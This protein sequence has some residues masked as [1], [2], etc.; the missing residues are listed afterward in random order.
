MSIDPIIDDAETRSRFEKLFKEIRLESDRG[1]ILV[2]A[3]VLDELCAQLIKERFAANEH[4]IKNAL[5]PLFA[6]MGPLSSFSARIK[7]AYCL[8]LIKQWEFEDL[9]KIRRIRNKAAHDYSAKTFTDNEIIQISQQLKGADHSVAWSQSKLPKSTEQ[10]EEAGGV[11]GQVMSKERIR[12]ILTVVYIAGRFDAHIETLA[13]RNK[14][15][16]I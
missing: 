2:G 14:K 13:N 4:V 1:C 11:S 8:G 10:A 12:F 6:T 9:E 15:A 7:L 5:D 3:S 16:T